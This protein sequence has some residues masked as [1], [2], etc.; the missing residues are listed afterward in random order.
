MSWLSNLGQSI[1]DV[2]KVPISYVPG[3][4]NYLGS[5]ESAD[6]V[7]DA[8]KKNLDATRETNAANAALW[9]EQTAYNTPVNQ[10][11]RL[12]DAGL[13]PNLAYGQVADSKAASPI[14]MQ[15]PRVEA[16]RGR[17]YSGFSLADYAQVVNLMETNK[18][19]RAQASKAVAE[20]EYADYETKKLKSSGMLK[21]D[22]GTIGGLFRYIFRNAA[23]R[24]KGTDFKLTPMPDFYRKGG[25]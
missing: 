12:R 7:R 3:V 16:P 24:L 15:A 4:G 17:D 10:M 2:A 23:D 25:D 11:Q 8:N 9:R 6:A 20:A 5:V 18:L 1:W 13:N 21:G 22:T 14:S 19:V